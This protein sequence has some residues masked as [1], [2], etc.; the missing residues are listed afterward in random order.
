MHDQSAQ[1]RGDELQ[2]PRRGEHDDH[3]VQRQHACQ[4]TCYGSDGDDLYCDDKRR[5][6]Q[7]LGY[8]APNLSECGRSCQPAVQADEYGSVQHGHDVSGLPVVVCSFSAELKDRLGS[9]PLARL[10][11][12]GG[13]ATSI[14]AWYSSSLRTLSRDSMDASEFERRLAQRAESISLHK[15]QTLTRTVSWSR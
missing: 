3:G 5:R 10:R 1:R 8:Y 7:L 11:S 6:W 15:N 4:H 13:R 2:H 14:D 12:A 9:A